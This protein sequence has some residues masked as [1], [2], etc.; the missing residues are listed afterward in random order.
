MVH[1]INYHLA[2]RL[3]SSGSSRT[4][5]AVSTVGKWTSHD[6]EWNYFDVP[7]LNLVHTQVGGIQLDTRDDLVV[8]LIQQKIGPFRFRSL[9]FV[10]RVSSRSVGYVSSVGPFLIL[11]E[12]TWEE[13]SN[14]E[15]KV[16]TR[17][18]IF[19]SKYLKPMHWIVRM[20]LKR[21]YAML[22]TEDVPMRVRRNE[23][24]RAGHSFY[25]DQEP[26]SFLRSKQTG[27]NNVTRDDSNAVEFDVPLNTLATPRT[28]F[29]GDSYSK[30]LR[31]DVGPTEIN[32]YPRM[33]VH[34]GACLDEVTPC[35]RSLVCPWHGRVIPPLATSY[36]S[37]VGEDPIRVTI[38]NQVILL[39]FTKDQQENVNSRLSGY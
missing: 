37:Q 18:Q 38:C 21:N 23:V 24:R 2:E 32:V 35:N 26:H 12:S 11:V 27:R 5:L 39:R 22:M 3:I 28:F 4:E 25:S 29:L 10:Y 33:C 30:G 1:H 15:T 14:G 36:I 31:I 7:H 6:V 13:I 8:S 17:Y 16:D 20:L 34:E 19:S 9:L